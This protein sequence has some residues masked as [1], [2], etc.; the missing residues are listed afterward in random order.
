MTFFLIDI[1]LSGFSGTADLLGVPNRGWCR[2]RAW[3]KSLHLSAAYKR[4]G[5]SQLRSSGLTAFGRKG[6]N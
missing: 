5:S 6:E 4:V 2:V 1:D 3:Q